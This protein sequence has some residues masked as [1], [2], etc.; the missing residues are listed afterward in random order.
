LQIWTAA[1][2]ILF[3]VKTAAAFAPVGQ[4]IRPKSRLPDFF[5]PQCTAEAKNPFGDV[6]VLFVISNLVK[7]F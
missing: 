4:T 7:K 3:V 2:V 5:I 6:T 1:E